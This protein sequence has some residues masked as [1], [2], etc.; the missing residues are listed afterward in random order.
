MDFSSGYLT[1]PDA[2]LKSGI[3]ANFNSCYRY[4]TRWWRGSWI[5][6]FRDRT[7][8]HLLVVRDELDV[9]GRPL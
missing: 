2:V 7:G 4:T 5:S 3:F 6:Q 1:G 9:I 8:D